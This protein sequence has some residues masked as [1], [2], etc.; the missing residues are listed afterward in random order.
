MRWIPTLNFQFVDQDYVALGSIF[1]NLRIEFPLK[2]LRIGHLPLLKE[3]KL[4]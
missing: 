4:G 1:L 2:K 3:G